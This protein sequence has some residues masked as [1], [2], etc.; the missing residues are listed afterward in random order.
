MFVKNATFA[1]VSE[2]TFEGIFSLEWHPMHFWT[3]KPVKIKCSFNSH[4]VYRR[5]FSARTSSVIPLG[6][7]E[8][9]LGEIELQWTLSVW[10]SKCETAIQGVI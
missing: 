1:K 10:I 3:F 9:F 7:P 4:A 2:F 6:E 8:R 5:L